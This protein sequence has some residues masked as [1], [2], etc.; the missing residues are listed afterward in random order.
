MIAKGQTVNSKPL[1]LLALDTATTGCS[2]TVWRDGEALA[3]DARE[4]SRGQSEA[5]LPMAVAALKSAGLVAADLNAIAV[6]RG[7]GAFTGMRI[8]LAAARGLAL[9][10]SIPCIGVTTLEAVAHGVQADE[11]SAHEGADL[12]IL[13]AVESKRA[14]IY[15]Q[16]FDGDLAPLGEPLAADGSALAALLNKGARVL[17]VGDAAERAQDMLAE[18]DVVAHLSAASSLPDTRIVAE[19]AARRFA[20]Q[21]KTVAPEPL[22]LRP[23]DAKLP[24]NAGRARA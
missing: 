20:P 3:H 11:R 8:G 13:A 17:A 1:T 18:H 5:L 4:M 15:V 7:P 22:Y 14:D 10:L 9:A 21:A 16:L 24:K 12:V 2:V 19:I 23:P 6:T